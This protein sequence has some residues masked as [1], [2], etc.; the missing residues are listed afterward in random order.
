M[1][2]S[3]TRLTHIRADRA[4]FDGTVFTWEQLGGQTG[5]EVE[6]RA[7]PLR[8]VS[9]E[10]SRSGSRREAALAAHKRA[11]LY[12]SARRSYSALRRNFESLGDHG[13]VSRAYRRE[14]QMGRS[15]AVWEAKAQWHEGERVQK[16]KRSV[17]HVYRYLADSAQW[18]LHDYGE[19]VIR[20]MLWLAVVFIG[21]GT[22]YWLTKSVVVLVGS[23][24]VPITNPGDYFLYSISSMTTLSAPNLQPACNGAQFAS[25]LEALAST[26]LFVL[27]GLVLS[28]RTRGS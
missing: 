1:D 19:S 26:V 23:D 28:N 20:V 4:W 27:L 5:E 11:D 8:P 25:T 3:S 10:R 24:K 17:P 16:L 22:G 14:R 18:L 12:A 6:A 15:Q 21:F 2:L 9:A 13:A 7:W